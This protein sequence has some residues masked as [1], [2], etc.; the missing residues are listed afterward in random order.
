MSLRPAG[1]HEVMP[2]SVRST[3]SGASRRGLTDD[4][5]TLD[6]GNA[7]FAGTFATASTTSPAPI[8]G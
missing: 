6:R 3:P 1:H 4:I 7:R 5:I 2:S 8:P